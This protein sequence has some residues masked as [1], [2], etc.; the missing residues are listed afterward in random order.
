MPRVAAPPRATDSPRAPQRTTGHPRAPLRTPAKPPRPVGNRPGRLSL[1]WRR[2]RR[3]WRKIALAL[4]AV[5]VVGGVATVLHAIDPARTFA[6]LQRRL[7]M[8]AGLTVQTI[9]IEGRHKTPEAKLRA[10]LGIS[11][12]DMLLGVSLDAVRARVEALNWVRQATVER[13]LPGTIIVTLRERSPFAVWQSGGKFVLIDRAGQVVEDGDPAKDAEVFASLPLVVGAGAPEAAAALLDIL[14][15]QPQLKE[16]VVAAV[17]VGERRWNLRLKNG[18]DVLLPED[19]AAA[20][21]AKLAEL[22]ASQQ[23]LDR[24]LQT[25]DMRLGDRLTIRPQTEPVPPIPPKRPT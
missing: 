24:P 10:A 21:L 17:R 5:I 12:G 23:L 13:R 16:R 25:V 14:A 22:Q 6:S 15:G 7:G 1:L 4:L 20:A 9:V 11:R 19:A 18:A 3:N 8:A 2:Q